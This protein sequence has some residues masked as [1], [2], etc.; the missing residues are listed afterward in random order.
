MG[1]VTMALNTV[2]LSFTLSN[3]GPC[4]ACHPFFSGDKNS[5]QLVPASGNSS[6]ARRRDDGRSHTRFAQ[7]WMGHKILKEEQRKIKRQE[8]GGSQ[9]EVSTDSGLTSKTDN[10]KASP[11]F[12]N[13]MANKFLDGL[14]GTTTKP[15][16]TKQY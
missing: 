8:T 11:G 9:E 3:S 13:L 10:P 2:I 15:G 7:Q 4:L 5:D 14:Q 12:I 6:L 16:R 1:S